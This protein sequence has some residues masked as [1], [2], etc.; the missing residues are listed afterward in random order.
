VH[1][2]ALEL[3]GLIINVSLNMKKYLRSGGR[4]RRGQCLL[5]LKVALVKIYGS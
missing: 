1:A 2:D 3:L 4:G 5:L